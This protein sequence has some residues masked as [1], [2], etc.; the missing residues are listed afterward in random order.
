MMEQQVVGSN[1]TR[2]TFINLVDYG[3]ELSLFWTVVGQIQQQEQIF[4][5]LVIRSLIRFL[6]PTIR[7]ARR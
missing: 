7:W 3:I 1:P 2:S 5:F 6:K 4:S